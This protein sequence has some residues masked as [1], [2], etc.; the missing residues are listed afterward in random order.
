[1]KYFKGISFYIVL[2]VI[3]LAILSII[4]YGGDLEQ[5]SYTDLI[6]EINTGD[7][8]N[9]SAIELE[10]TKATVTLKNPAATKFTVIIPSVDIF[11]NEIG[12][13]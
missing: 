12:I 9:V 2:L 5:K 3:I 8:G 4:G 10:G 7:K 11:M 6:R 1:L 13:V